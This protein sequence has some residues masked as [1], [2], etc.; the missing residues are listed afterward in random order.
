MTMNPLQRAKS[1]SKHMRIGIYNGEDTHLLLYTRDVIIKRN[2]KGI[3]WTILGFHLFVVFMYMSIVQATNKTYYANTYSNSLCNITDIIPSDNVYQFVIINSTNMSCEDYGNKKQ[4]V[5]DADDIYVLRT[6]NV[7]VG[8]IVS[9]YMKTLKCNH[10]HFDGDRMEMN[11]MY[12]VANLLFGSIIC[13]ITSL[14][15]WVMLK[16]DK[17]KFY[18]TQWDTTLDKYL[19]YD[20][21]M[22]QWMRQ[23]NVKLYDDIN[24]LIFEYADDTARVNENSNEFE[25]EGSVMS[26]W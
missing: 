24:E 19:R 25:Q 1:K 21:V 22:D 15:V 7:S 11:Q 18:A 14:S 9:C 2:K 13:V 12:L 6:A 20:F 4:L 3:C 10:V 26:T 17:F 8:T 23:C 5:K 16:K